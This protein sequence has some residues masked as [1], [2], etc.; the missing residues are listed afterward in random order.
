MWIQKQLA[1]KGAKEHANC[2]LD[3]ALINKNRLRQKNSRWSQQS[4][5]QK[6]MCPPPRIKGKELRKGV[7][8]RLCVEFSGSAI[9]IFVGPLVG[10]TTGESQRGLL[11]EY[12]GRAFT[13]LDNIQ[14]TFGEPF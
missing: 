13:G 11:K 7:S 8:G 3:K 12:L 9:D 5:I 6:R 10:A 4:Q 2:Q 14:V 1:R